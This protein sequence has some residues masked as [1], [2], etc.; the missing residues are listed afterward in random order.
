MARDTVTL[1]DCA[2]FHV[3]AELFRTRRVKFGAVTE[4]VWRQTGLSWKVRLSPT[5]SFILMGGDRWDL[6]PHVVDNLTDGV[7]WFVVEHD[8]GNRVT[9]LYY[10]PT[11]RLGSRTELGLR[12][13]SARLC[14][15]NRLA[16]ARMKVIEK[17]DGPTD[18]AWVRQ[19][20]HYVPSKRPRGMHPKT[21]S[22]LRRKLFRRLPT[23][24]VSWL[25]RPGHAAATTA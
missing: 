23:D 12:H 22:K 14:T 18:F 8:T 1:E 9:S 19:H 24:D 11:G 20:P 21:F 4:G 17:I 7:R 3:Q 13:R 25:R 5:G 10:T 2:R 6:V 16:W 15:P